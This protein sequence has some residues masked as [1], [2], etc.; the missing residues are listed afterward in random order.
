MIY[1]LLLQRDQL[2]GCALT[3]DLTTGKPNVTFPESQTRPKLQEMQRDEFPPHKAGWHTECIVIGSC[4]SS[5][6]YEAAAGL[7]CSAGSITTNIQP[8]V[9]NSFPPSHPHPAA[10]PH[11]PNHEIKTEKAG[12]HTGCSGSQLQPPLMDGPGKWQMIAVLF[13]SPRPGKN[14]RKYAFR[15]ERTGRWGGTGANLHDMHIEGPRFV[16]SR[17]VDMVVIF[18]AH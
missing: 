4:A 16:M 8:S 13:R 11:V 2:S 1:L 17:W 18:C 10:F 9:F 15:L 12:Q 3:L 14:M 6:I 7:L 5:G